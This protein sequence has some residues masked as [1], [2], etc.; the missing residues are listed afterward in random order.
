M[1]PRWRCKL[2]AW[3]RLALPQQVRG[4]I[5]RSPPVFVLLTNS[6]MLSSS[7]WYT[8]SKMGLSRFS[9]KHVSFS[10]QTQTKLLN[11]YWEQLC[12]NH[13]AGENE[14]KR[15]N[16]IQRYTTIEIT[17][18]NSYVGYHRT[19]K[20]NVLHANNYVIPKHCRLWTWIFNQGG[21]PN[22]KPWHREQSC[23]VLTWVA[24]SFQ[25]GVVFVLFCFLLFFSVFCFLQRYSLSQEHC[26]VTHDSNTDETQ[27]QHIQ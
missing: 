25:G 20:T 6:T 13:Y 21:L 19:A 14:T 16:L 26:H 9:H 27:E 10:S 24:I 23:L 7:R 2:L 18:W 8:L 11:I 12:S 17:T 4:W 1:R 22:Y 15:Q 3:A 5:S